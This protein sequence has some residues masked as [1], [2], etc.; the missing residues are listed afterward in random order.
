VKYETLGV[1]GDAMS[2]NYNNFLSGILFAF[3][4]I[5][6]IY[7]R[8]TYFSLIGIVCN[9]EQRKKMSNVVREMSFYT[10]S[11]SLYFF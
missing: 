5:A 6:Y 7:I 11:N 1:Y 8:T 2:N 3:I 4:T 10:L 9:Q